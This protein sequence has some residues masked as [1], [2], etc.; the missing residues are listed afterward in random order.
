MF[1]EL[2]FDIFAEGGTISAIAFTAKRERGKRFHS[3]PIKS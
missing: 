1:P 3:L 2:I